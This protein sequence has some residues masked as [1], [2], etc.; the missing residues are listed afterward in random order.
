VTVSKRICSHPAD[1]RAR[2]GGGTHVQNKKKL[3]SSREQIFSRGRTSGD[4]KTQ[5]GRSTPT[6]IQFNPIIEGAGELPRVPWL[7]K[8][9]DSGGEDRAG[10]AI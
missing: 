5:Q 1:H 8:K 7:K 3:S 10:I 6:R 2:V 9:N 4:Q